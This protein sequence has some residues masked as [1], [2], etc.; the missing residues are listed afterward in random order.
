MAQTPSQTHWDPGN[1]KDKAR[2]CWFFKRQL[3]VFTES[4]II[5]NKR[6]IVPSGPAFFP[7]KGVILEKNG[8]WKSQGRSENIDQHLHPNHT[9]THHTHTHQSHT[10]PHPPHIHTHT[11]PSYT[12]P[13]CPIT[14]GTSL[15][16]PTSCS[17]DICHSQS[18]KQHWEISWL[19][20]VGFHVR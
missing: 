11:H 1:Y 15:C 14:Q 9:H 8:S 20:H 10:H 13:P 6:S 16:T 7:L 17:S 2:H 18:Q 12:Q 5:T 4:C 19:L 3:Q